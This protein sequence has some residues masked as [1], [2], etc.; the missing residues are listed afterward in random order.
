MTGRLRVGIIGC[1]KM[2]RNHVGGEV[3]PPMRT[4]VSGLLAASVAAPIA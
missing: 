3:D 4:T 2:A 1:G